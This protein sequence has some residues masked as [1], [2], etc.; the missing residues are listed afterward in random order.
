MSLCI[1]SATGSCTVVGIP[2]DPE[3]AVKDLT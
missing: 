3:R 1:E 2:P